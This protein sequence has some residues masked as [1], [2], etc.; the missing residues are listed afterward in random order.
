[1]QHPRIPFFFLDML[2]FLPKSCLMD[3]LHQKSFLKRKKKKNQQNNTTPSPAGLQ[4]AFLCHHTY[5]LAVIFLYRLELDRLDRWAD[6]NGMRF[7]KSKCWVLHFAT[8]TPGNAVGLGQS[9]WKAVWKSIQHWGCWLTC[10]TAVCPGGH[11]GQ[12]HPAFYQK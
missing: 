11:E 9:G 10:E 4:L 5:S 3:S 12:Q 8:T 7:S 1:M 6:A 2:G